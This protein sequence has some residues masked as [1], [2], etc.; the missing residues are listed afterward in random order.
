M[1]EREREGGRERERGVLCVLGWQ[2]ERKAPSK[3]SLLSSLS[4]HLAIHPAS[5][6]RAP[7]VTLDFSRPFGPPIPS[8]IT[9]R[10]IIS[11][12][13]LA[14]SHDSPA[15]SVF[16]SLICFL[17]KG[18]C[19]KCNSDHVTL[20]KTSDGSPLAKDKVHL[21]R[22]G[23]K[24]SMNQPSLLSQRPP[25]PLP[26]PH[27]IDQLLTLPR[28]TA[29]SSRHLRCHPGGRVSAVPATS[30]PTPYPPMLR[31]VLSGSAG[32]SSIRKPP[33]ALL[34]TRWVTCVSRESP[35]T[36]KKLYIPHEITIMCPR[37][38]PFPAFDLTE[39]KDCLTHLCQ[40][41]APSWSFT[42]RQCLFVESLQVLRTGNS[43]P[44]D[45]KWY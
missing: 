36:T 24:A 35:S 6:A 10:S 33:H 38:S 11:S 32:A 1:C 18:I 5:W 26:V 7:G 4:C 2:V 31:L 27:F 20:L 37:L 41:L 28:C 13:P 8:V 12:W 40:H 39:V 17:C 21:Y 9:S 15:G 3:Q 42:R 25:L 23:P 44:S 14:E 22:H 19:L 43:Q 16:L 30:S 29:G 45:W 34:H